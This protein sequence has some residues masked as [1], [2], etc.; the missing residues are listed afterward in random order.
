MLGALLWLKENN[1]YFHDIP[2]NHTALAQ[3]PEDGDC[4]GI[5]TVT[6]ETPEGEE[7]VREASDDPYNAF[8]PGSFVP[9]THKKETEQQIVQQAVSPAGSAAQPLAWP[10][11]GSAPINELTDLLLFLSPGVS[12]ARLSL[13]CCLCRSSLVVSDGELIIYMM[14]AF[15]SLFPTG[16]ADFS[17]P[18]LHPV[19]IGY[20]FKH[21]MMYKD[22]RFGK[23][24]RFRYF[25]LNTEMRWRALQAGRI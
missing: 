22:G 8:L 9:V 4:S 24:P 13:S 21:L 3:L 5:S 23:H 20:Y 7:D 11:V 16:A 14:L 2:L 25:A 1:T 19:T 6:L 12:L 17:A 10:Q 18:R 15:P